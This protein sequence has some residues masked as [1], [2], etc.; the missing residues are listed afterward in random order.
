MK[1]LL[2]RPGALGDTVVWLPAAEQWLSGGGGE[3]WCA[4][5]NADVVRHLGTVRAIE[6][7]GLELLELPGAEVPGALI[8][9]LRSFDEIISW[10]GTARAEFRE[11]L[12]GLGVKA[13]FLP[14]LPGDVG[15]VHAV[16]F[17]LGQVGATA[18]GVPR[19]PVPLKPVQ[20]N[21]L[22]RESPSDPLSA[23]AV[24]RL[25]RDGGYAVIHPFSG[26]RKKNWPLES[27]RAIAERLAGVMDVRW[28][29]GPEE[30]LDG[31][32]RF[33]RTRGLIEFLAGARVYLG[34]DS[35]PTHLAAA[36]GTPVVA[37][38][39]PSDARVWAPRGE[40]VEVLNF[41]TRPN[42]VAEAVLRAGNRR[43]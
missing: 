11:A 37:M 1:R 2:I 26:S 38:F 29:A 41:Q 42:E 5:A 16:D 34:N 6:G 25:W 40:F 4:G 35:G 39:G 20:G 43:R 3:I 8:D 32:W 27:F 14:A 28:C 17:Y 36:V 23:F 10:Y 21:P 12:I 7:S 9:R 30:E 22:C 33:E 15:T 19:V 31:A 24:S 18:G 13:R